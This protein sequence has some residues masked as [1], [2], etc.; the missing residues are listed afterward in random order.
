MYLRVCRNSQRLHNQLRSQPTLLGHKMLH[1][2]PTTGDSKASR[3][4][5]KLN[6]K[7]YEAE[8]G[9]LRVHEDLR[10]LGGT[11]SFSC[12]AGSASAGYGGAAYV[13]GRLG[14]GPRKARK[15]RSASSSSGPQKNATVRRAA[16]I[17]NR[18]AKSVILQCIP[19]NQTGRSCKEQCPIGTSLPGG[20]FH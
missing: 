3:K 1:P 19:R 18:E 11:L 17:Q 20:R 8:G 15:A 14:A 7:E 2:T 5:P 13:G 4:A 12:Y 9:G 16:L 6:R 10:L